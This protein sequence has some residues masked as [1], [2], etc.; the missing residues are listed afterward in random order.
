AFGGWCAAVA[1]ASGK[2]A[3]D[4]ILMGRSESG[5][6]A[7]GAGGGSSTMPQK[8]NPV[9]AETTVALAR[10][11]APLAAALHLAT[12]HAEERDGAAWALEWLALPQLALCAGA[13]L[14][15][16]LALA[17]S[18]APRPD[19]MR[20]ILN[21]D[22]GAA[23][24]EAATFRLAALAPRPEAERIVREALEAAR[25]EGLRLQDVLARAFPG[26]DWAEALDPAARF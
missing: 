21:A 2:M 5:E 8:A 25:S 24:A 11:A 3:G 4:L 26:I 17:G 22:G 1:G 19:R 13:A 10:Y 18:L 15:H 23:M 7:A 20:A 16:G 14:R 12:L 9:A 6:A